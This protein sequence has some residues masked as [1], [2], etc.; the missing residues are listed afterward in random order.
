MRRVCPVRSGKTAS[1][2]R[3]ANALF[4]GQALF[5]FCGV[6][7]LN[8]YFIEHLLSLNLWAGE[9]GYKDISWGGGVRFCK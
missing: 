7:G 9:W 4:V 1:W 3:E 6:I 5:P 2:V 8:K